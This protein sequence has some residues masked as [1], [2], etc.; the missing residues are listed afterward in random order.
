MAETL[1]I[2]VSE[3]EQKRFKEL[4]EKLEM[5]HGD[6]LTTMMNIFQMDKVSKANPR[7]E[8]DITKFLEHMAQIQRLFTNLAESLGQQHDLAR[9]NVRHEL[10]SKDQ[11]IADLQKRTELAEAAAKDAEATKKRLMQTEKDLEEA[12]RTI[13]ALTQIRDTM[14]DPQKYADLAKRVIE[15]EAASIEKDKLIEKLLSGRQAEEE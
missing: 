2:R 8:L 15:L 14:P 1:Q 11:V 4:A 6:A 5:K 7:L 13:K 12:R 10:E 3:E 9:E